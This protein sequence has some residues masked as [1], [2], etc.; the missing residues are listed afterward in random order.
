MEK[1]SRLAFIDLHR[2]LV[3]LLMIE[4]HVFNAF[5]MQ[6]YRPTLWFMGLNFINGLV[7]PSFLFISGFAFILASQKKLKEFRTLG[8]QFYRQIGRILLI[9]LAGYS[10]H[11]PF[12]N[13][14]RTLEK[15]TS[16]QW[17]HLF[18]IDVLQCIAVSLLLLFLLR[19]LITD[20]KWF[21]YVTGFITL[22][23]ILPAPYI[24]VIDFSGM[25][26]PALA[27]YFNKMSGSL[28]PVFPWSGFL[29]LGAFLSILFSEFRA[30]QEEERYFSALK[31]TAVVF[32]VIGSVFYIE[33]SPLHIPMMKP[34]I[35]FFILRAGYIFLIFYGCYL[36]AKKGER[37]GIKIIS[38]FGRESLLVYWLHLQVIYRKIGGESLNGTY[39]Y[40]FGVTESIAATLLLAG[41]MWA[42]AYGWSALK[43][44]FPR[45]FQY[46]TP[47][48]VILLILFYLLT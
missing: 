47:A 46:G 35:T 16:E 7:A 10:L 15:S 19:L 48:A 42:A 18:A 4:V 44:D 25:M 43:S 41:L 34:E 28:F 17:R 5:L 2:G 37:S 6:T 23:F 9:L 30:R 24:W 12:F 13:L 1:T 29:F 31:Y 38:G 33:Q 32:I 14:S 20:D 21:K 8:R 40:T 22:V 11:L 27:A 45:L 26:H 36:F 39:K 3:L